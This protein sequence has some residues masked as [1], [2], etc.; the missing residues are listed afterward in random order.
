MLLTFYC[1]DTFGVQTRIEG[2]HLTTDSLDQNQCDKQNVSI[3]SEINHPNEKDGEIQVLKKEF[4]SKYPQIENLK[5][6]FVKALKEKDNLQGQLQ[7]YRNKQLEDLK[8]EKDTLQNENNTLKNEKD[9]LQRNLY[10]EKYKHMED[11][12][13]EKEDKLEKVKSKLVEQSKEIEAL[14]RQVQ[15]D[16]TQCDEKVFEIN[17]EKEKVDELQKQLMNAMNE[18]ARWQK[19]ASKKIIEE[20]CITDQQGV[21]RQ[22]RKLWT[23]VAGKR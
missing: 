5:S 13:K 1:Q 6:D 19:V 9:K 3:D 11:I 2:T 14:Q 10:E 8:K 12:L 16:K 20:N 7:H 22:Y 15:I 17:K 21:T 23:Q 4:H 18:S